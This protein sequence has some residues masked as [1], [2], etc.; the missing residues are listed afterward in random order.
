M[1]PGVKNFI[2]QFKRNL[3]LQPGTNHRAIRRNDGASVPNPQVNFTGQPDKIIT[4]K[5]NN[6]IAITPGPF[7]E[8]V[9]DLLM[10]AMENY[11]LED[12]DGEE[13]ES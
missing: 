13:K 7:S 9:H 1:K 8:P 5:K 2:E 10:W 3:I 6:F 11:P 4:D 12:K